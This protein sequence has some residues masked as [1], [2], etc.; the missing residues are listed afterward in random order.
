M[1]ITGVGVETGG[2]YPKSD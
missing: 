2:N 1:L